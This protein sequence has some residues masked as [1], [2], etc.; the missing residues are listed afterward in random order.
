[1]GG[2]AYPRE[3]T[4]WS[5]SCLRGECSERHSAVFT[6][7]PSR[8]RC[9]SRAP[10]ASSVTSR[11]VRGPVVPVGRDGRAITTPIGHYVRA[12]SPSRETLA[13]VPLPTSRTEESSCAFDSS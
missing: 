1:M 11:T 3:R 9:D 13:V 10:G 2:A 6:F 5:R 8:E 7:S 12:P 4:P